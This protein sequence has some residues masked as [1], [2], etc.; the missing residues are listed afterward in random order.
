M[1][2]RL[3]SGIDP[4]EQRSGTA[5]TF[6][7]TRADFEVAWQGLFGPSLASRL[8]GM[9]RS[10]G[11]DSLEKREVGARRRAS[12]VSTGQA[13]KHATSRPFADQEAAARKFLEIGDEAKRSRTAAFISR[14]S[15]FRD[16]G[17]P[18]EMVLPRLCHR[19]ELAV[20]ARVR[21]LR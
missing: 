10:A 15:I 20:E 5:A 21:E 4:D 2:M 3:L 18:A 1:A 9:T 11:L 16:G 13:M 12:P 17:S 7:Q 14:I 8:A 19:K 6:N